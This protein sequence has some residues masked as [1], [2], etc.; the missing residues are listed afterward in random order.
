MSADNKKDH[1]PAK[2]QP[3]HVNNIVAWASIA[4]ALVIAFGIAMLVIK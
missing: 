1:A 3:K 2:K 4:A